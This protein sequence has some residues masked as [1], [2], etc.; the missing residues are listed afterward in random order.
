MPDSNTSQWSWF[1]VILGYLIK[2]FLFGCGFV[3]EFCLIEIVIIVCISWKDASFICLTVKL[4]WVATL[5]VVFDVMYITDE[6]T[7][8]GFYLLVQVTLYNPKNLAKLMALMI[9]WWF[10]SFFNF[11]FL[12]ILLCNLVSAQTHTW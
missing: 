4:V 5:V 10:Y 12:R 6:V 11:L 3:L 8:D 2:T 7:V 1:V 9:F